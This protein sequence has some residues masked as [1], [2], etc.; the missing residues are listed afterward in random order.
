[1]ARVPGAGFPEEREK[2]SPTSARTLA[3]VGAAEKPGG[4]RWGGEF[5]KAADVIREFQGPSIFAR[6]RRFKS[7]LLAGGAAN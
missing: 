2:S 4:A 6:R 3:A 1:M 7:A 5:D